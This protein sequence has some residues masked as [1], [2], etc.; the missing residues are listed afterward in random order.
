MKNIKN[1]LASQLIPLF[2]ILI[3]LS[4]CKKEST[5]VAEKAT[6]DSKNL[7]KGIEKSKVVDLEHGIAKSLAKIYAGNHG[8]K[9]ALENLCLK[10][11]HGDYYTRLS[12]LFT[13]NN[14]QK[15]ASSNQI[16]SITSLVK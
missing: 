9:K 13:E 12:E 4:S 10:Q 11:K 7:S 14:V 1:Y 3:I 16:E 6:L 8:F 5:Q 2:G 15:L